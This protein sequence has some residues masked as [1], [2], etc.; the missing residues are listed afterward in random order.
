MNLVLSFAHRIQGKLDTNNQYTITVSTLQ[1]KAIVSKK[2][3]TTRELTSEWYGLL[4]D[5]DDGYFLNLAI[6]MGM[7][8]Q[9]SLSL[10]SSNRYS[11]HLKIVAGLK[12]VFR[13][14]KL[15]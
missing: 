9:E 10:G 13:F 4:A 12:L 5:Q 3:T 6:C 1:L 15:N 11:S 7:N 14:G 8:P 2:I